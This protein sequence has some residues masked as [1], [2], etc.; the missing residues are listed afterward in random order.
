MNFLATFFLSLWQTLFRLLSLVGKDFKLLLRSKTSALVVI[1]GPLLVVG[2]IGVAF[3]T[4]A[5]YD[6]TISTYSGSYS[7]LSEQLLDSLEA[8]GY[9]VLRSA[10]LDDCLQSVTRGDTH[11]CLLF[12]PDISLAND[13]KNKITFYVD[14]SRV[15]LVYAIMDQIAGEITQ[16]TDAL[17]L[18]LTQVLVQ[19][20]DAAKQE[21]AQR[22]STINALLANNLEVQDQLSA[23]SGVLAAIDLRIDRGSFRID[24]LRAARSEI[25]AASNVSTTQLGQEITRLENYV[26]ELIDSVGDAKSTLASSSSA[27]TNTQELVST[28][29][30]TLG[31]VKSSVLGV[32]QGI[33][34]IAVTDAK[35]IVTPIGIEVQPVAVE[36]TYLGKLFPTF[37]ALV[38]MF[39]AIILSSTLVM[40]EKETNAYFRNFITPTSDIL[41]LLSTA[42][43]ALLILLF[44]FLLILGASYFFVQ[45][46][47]LLLLPALLVPFFL[48]SLLF[49][50]LGIV[51]GYLFKSRETSALASLFVVCAAL[52]FSNTILPLE[53]VPD[54][55]RLLIPLNPFVLA[56]EVLKKMFL[57]NY[58]LA[59][60][61]DLLFGLLRYAAILLVVAYGALKISKHFVKTRG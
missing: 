50:F 5:I 34:G 46:Q 47:F 55:M 19:E 23:T 8:S 1:F 44:Q 15:N 41:F 35:Q 2:L 32:T 25:G 43:T 14:Y 31:E 42:L 28:N 45:M 53:A 17:S 33:E 49:I 21:L 4:S 12:S 30:Q 6:V 7:P 59:A 61:E 3:N 11:V 37:L 26:N 36:R 48:I 56:E 39:V 52:F 13:K 20:L 54:F 27:L 38:L 16:S 18:E 60:L 57:F 51:I 40:N 24:E 22:I 10:T 29:Q 9:F 58:G